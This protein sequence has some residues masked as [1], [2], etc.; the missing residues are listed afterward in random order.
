MFLEGEYVVKKKRKRRT[1]P[2]NNIDCCK[3]CK[4]Q[5][6]CDVICADI[7]NDKCY[8][9]CKPGSCEKVIEFNSMIKRV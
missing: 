9:T 3:K 2:K 5:D 1:S 4:H 7:F 6:M 8:N